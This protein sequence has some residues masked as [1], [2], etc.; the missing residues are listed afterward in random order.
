MFPWS[1]LY[2]TIYSKISLVYYN[3]KIP[4]DSKL[5]LKNKRGHGIL[6]KIRWYK[7]DLF[8]ILSQYGNPYM[9][10]K[11]DRMLS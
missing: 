5:N 7:Y 11:R 6:N 9:S 4:L 8:S 3:L 2:F 10:I 1:K